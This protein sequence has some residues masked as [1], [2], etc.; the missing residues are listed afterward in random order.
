MP[1]F[2]PGSSS[3]SS[4]RLSP[5]AAGSPAA[6]FFPGRRA[7]Q[8]E[9]QLDPHAEFKRDEPLVEGWTAPAAEALE[10]EAQGRASAPS[11]L[12]T[13]TLLEPA[14]VWEPAPLAVDAT[15]VEAA[16][17][18]ADAVE[19]GEVE[20]AFEVSEITS[21]A[22][23]SFAWEEIGPEAGLPKG[24]ALDEGLADPPV[25][26]SVSD[27]GDAAEV[28][29]EAAASVDLGLETL[30]EETDSRER[31]LAAL[32][33]VA[34]QLRAGEIVVSAPAG[35]TPE[36]ILASILATLLATGTQ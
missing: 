28:Q 10:S 12:H 20:S 13:D 25:L 23:A 26:Q 1:L 7:E 30:V 29:L 33:A 17:E 21:E 32:D 19:A 3:A 36:A 2:R 4:P 31:A 16:I 14:P 6:P 27:S 15:P 22:E 35:A 34:R 18:G 24:E 9:S 5:R 11:V 8:V